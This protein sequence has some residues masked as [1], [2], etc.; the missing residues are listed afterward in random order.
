P[1]ST[2]S[3]AP[4]AAPAGQGPTGTVAEPR[5]AA[6]SP[7]RED[8]TVDP[9]RGRAAAGEERTVILPRKVA[10]TLQLKRVAPSGQAE[11]LTL[12]RP[13]LMLGR[14]HGC[15]V[16]LFTPT[17]S[18]E[19][20]RMW[21][22]DGQW[23]IAALERKSLYIDGVRQAEGEVR[24][25]NGMRLRLGDDELVVVEA[26]EAA[27]GEVPSGGSWARLVAFVKGLFG[28]RG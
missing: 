26:G 7:A 12:E 5:A 8:V 28:R 4:P 6:P 2:P 25:R 10:S 27:A 14:G 23:R 24:L 22:Q 18:R 19:H 20:A 15:D 11:T 13:N 17:A 21:F 3:A 16:K 9:L 1:P